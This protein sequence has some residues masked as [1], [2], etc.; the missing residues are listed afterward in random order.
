MGKPEL[1]PALRR[2]LEE[3]I[4]R[5]NYHYQSGYERHLSLQKP[6]SIM[7]NFLKKKVSL[8]PPHYLLRLKAR[9]LYLTMS[10]D[11]FVN[12]LSFSDLHWTHYHDMTEWISLLN[13][14]QFLIDYEELREKSKTL[15]KFH[16]Q[17]DRL[18][19]SIIDFKFT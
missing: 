4:M 13:D 2:E 6:E 11:M 18:I 10:P 5:V 14:A 16:Q 12:R 15:D 1:V 3:A 9:E 19:N 17:T 8:V 7:L